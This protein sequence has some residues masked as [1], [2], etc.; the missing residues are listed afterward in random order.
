MYDT[1]NRQYPF[2]QIKVI[3]H[4]ELT[5][6]LI[7][8]KVIPLKPTGFKLLLISINLPKVEVSLNPAYCWE[9][10]AINLLL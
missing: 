3:G 4:I 5:L 2:L 9:K 10:D 8:F 7:C 6:D 1:K